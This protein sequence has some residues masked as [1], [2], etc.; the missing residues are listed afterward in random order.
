[1]ITRKALMILHQKCNFI[2]NIWREYDDDF[3]KDGAKIGSTLRIR[4]PNKYLTSVGAAITPQD[5]VETSTTLVVAT[6]RN[7][8]MQFLSSELTL[9]MDDFTERIIDPAA[10]VLA[11]GIEG[12]AFS[13]ALDV[14]NEIGTP[15]VVPA[16]LLVYLTAKAVLDN[17]LA[18]QSQ[19]CVHV[20]PL[21]SAVILNS[22]KTL[23]NPQDTI[24]KQYHDGV[25]GRAADFDWYAN[26]LLPSFTPGSNLTGITVSGAGQ[27]GA[28]LITT[29][30]VAADTVKKGTVFTI[31]GLFEVHPETKAPTNTLRQLVVTADQTAAGA[32]MTLAI[33]PPIITTGPYQNVVAS[34]VTTTPL[35]F[36]GT[37]SVPYRLALAFHKQAFTF[38]APPLFMPKGVDMGSRQT[39]DGISM[40][41]I[42]DYVPTSDQLVTRLDVLY[43]YKTIRPDIACRIAA[44]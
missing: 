23:F 4:L 24:S 19:R 20:D 44:S 27:T 22:L 42:R 34:P 11:S 16:D 8:P 37:A 14:F 1:M 6:Q 15:G 12:D 35:V 39:Q 28:S 13:M 18:P 38:A 9:S 31:A 36:R 7:V 26:T 21:A 32:A 17:N 40:R 25:M 10:A 30:W 3:G 5:T 33:S 41:L 29:G 2:T 43:G